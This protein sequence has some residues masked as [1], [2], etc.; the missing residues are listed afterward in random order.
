[1]LDVQIKQ[2]VDLYYAME[3]PEIKEDASVEDVRALMKRFSNS[4][5]AQPLSSQCKI[6]TF[7]VNTS[8][9]EIQVRG[10]YP[11]GEI[12]LN[13]IL[14][15]RGAG[16]VIDNLQDSDAFCI[17][18]AEATRTFVLSVDYPLAPEHPYP[19]SLEASYEVY[20]WAVEHIEFSNS[21]ASKIIVM[22]ESS[23]GCLVGNLAQMLRDRKGPQMGY[24]ILLYPVTDFNLEREAYQKLGSHYILTKNKMSWYL[25][26]Y[27]PEKEERNQR[28][29]FPMNHEDLRGLPKTLIVTAECDPLS[30]EGI[31]YGE[32]LKEAQNDCEVVCYAGLIH[33]FMKFTAI[34]KVEEA[35]LH[36]TKRIEDFLK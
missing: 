19:I 20:L 26:Q 25:S 2:L 24:Q 7:K 4:S 1:M 18:L 32:L 22:G 31:S 35:F 3:L 30:E 17:R 34:K 28:Y 10:Y 8:I 12:M 14:F 27:L 21:E 9:G 16:F 29:A 23:G 11:E 36:L 13:P 6:K 15:F 33:G 5:I